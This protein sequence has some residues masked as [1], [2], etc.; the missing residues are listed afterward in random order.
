MTELATIRDVLEAAV[1]RSPGKPYLIFEDQTITYRELRSRVDRAANA[2]RSLG[3]ARGDRVSLLLPNAPAFLECWL[4]LS[5]LGASMVPVNTA[6]RAREA[7][8]V[9]DHSESRLLVAD[10]RYLEVAREAAAGCP[11]LDLGVATV[12]APAGPE[13]PF[14]ALARAASD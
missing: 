3:I 13:P 6:F 5:S 2:F 10:G 14:D 4:G 11:R 1:S 7:Q 12:G 9:V 8:Y